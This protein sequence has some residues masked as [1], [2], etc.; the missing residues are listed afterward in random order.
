MGV[1]LQ[2][3]IPHSPGVYFFKNNREILYV[4]KAANLKSRVSSYFLKNLSSLK[5]KSLLKESTSLSWEVL[6][7]ETEALI[8]ESELIKKYQPKYNVLMRDDKQYFFVGFSKEQFPKIYLTHQTPKGP[9]YIGPFTDG[10]AIKSVLKLLRRAFPY[11]TCTRPHKNLCL[12][13]R[14]ERCLGYCC[15]QNAVSHTPYAVS[16]K[17][18]ISSI[19][20]I[21]T[22]KNKS[23]VKTLRKEMKKFSSSQKYEEAGKIRNQIRALEKIFAHKEI[24][25]RD[26][27]SENTKAISTLES[28]IKIKEIK[29][30]E[31]YDI[32]NIQ[33]K[34]AYGSMAVFIDGAPMKDLYRIF[35][36]KSVS[37][38]NDVAM[39][40]EVITRRFQHKEWE[41]PDVILVDGGKA[42][43]GAIL[44]PIPS[45]LAPKVI[46]LTKNKKHIGD[47]IYISGKK[48]P[49]PL[50][51]LPSPLKNLLLNLDSEAHRFAIRHYRHSHRNMLT[52]K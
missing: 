38:P 43:M 18:N 33:G 7:S 42:Q 32:A 4:G 49:I 2:T 22:G 12:N 44:D 6:N 50:S 51:S 34:Y 20:K 30:M 39:L 14:I 36:I 24:I 11:C 41:Y 15:T 35:K 47:H 10:A 19:K 13:A 52:S 28:L 25:S 45:T 17:N 48:D 46:A 27:V 31:A 23:L 26:M 37:G 21:L 1:K 9:E 29:R 16:Y 5:V 8:K 40:K 3:K